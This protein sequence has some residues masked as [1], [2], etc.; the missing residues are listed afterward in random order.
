M[1]CGCSGPLNAVLRL[2]RVTLD[3]TCCAV[4]R[5]AVPLLAGLRGPRRLLLLQEEKVSEVEREL[6]EAQQRAETAKST[7][8]VIVQ[9]M[10]EEL[11]R[12]QRERAREMAAV[13]RDF[14][15]L[16]A[17]LASNQSKSW[18]ALLEEAV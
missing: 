13:L 12:F 11:A 17:E 15:L 18:R 3:G 5:C 10:A 2:P 9:Q 16:Q 6:N 1:R 8:Q 7:Y 14:A 4:L